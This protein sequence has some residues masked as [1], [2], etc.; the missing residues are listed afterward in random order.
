MIG[1]LKQ[2]ININNFKNIQNKYIYNLIVIITIQILYDI[3]YYI[4]T[5]DILNVLQHANYKYII[6]ILFIF[7][8]S[9][10]KYSI[11][12]FNMFVKSFKFYSCKN[13]I[14]LNY[15]KTIFYN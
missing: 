15:S 6:I 7:I 1:N 9:N 4:N 3:W 2:Y 13:S 11:S 8:H 14:Y 5:I 10:I 12:L